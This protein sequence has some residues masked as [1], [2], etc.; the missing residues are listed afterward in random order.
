F[1]GEKE[2]IAVSFE[3]PVA[4]RDENRPGA[5]Q[6]DKP[7][8]K[9]IKR[10]R[11]AP[12][13]FDVVTAIICCERQPRLALRE[14]RIRICIPLHRRAASVTANADARY[15]HFHRIA[16]AYAMGCRC[17][18]GLLAKQAVAAARSRLLLSQ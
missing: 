6:G 14:A 18:C 5:A 13:P 7:A 9:I 1:P 4:P 3:R 16:D 8:I 2:N 10:G 11:I 15:V 12:L 17:E